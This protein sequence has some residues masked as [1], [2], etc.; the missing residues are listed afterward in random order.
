MDG[1]GE[2]PA[3]AAGMGPEQTAAASAPST[4]EHGSHQAGAAQPATEVCVGACMCVCVV[5]CGRACVHMCVSVCV[6]CVFGGFA[7][8]HRSI[9]RGKSFEIRNAFS[10]VTL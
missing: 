5:A 1:R 7:M 2:A 6:W 4:G 9:G 3:P 8:H 10:S